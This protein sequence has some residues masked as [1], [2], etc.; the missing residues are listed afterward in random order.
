[1]RRK[2]LWSALTLVFGSLVL[3]PCNALTRYGA[4]NLV[5]WIPNYEFQG[6]ISASFGRSVLTVVMYNPA[7]L[8]NFDNSFSQFLLGRQD[9]VAYLA[10]D[11]IRS[12]DL[13]KRPDDKYRGSQPFSLIQEANVYS[14]WKLNGLGA[15]GL[16]CIAYHGLGRAQKADLRRYVESQAN[17]GTVSNIV[18]LPTQRTLIL[19]RLRRLERDDACL[20][21]F[22]NF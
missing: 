6:A 21:I 17:R 3:L 2:Y 4:G 22:K 20:G 18:I 10:M 9:A 11:E 13:F 14:H 19:D 5:E 15:E 7:A 12:Y 16:D 8:A 1:M